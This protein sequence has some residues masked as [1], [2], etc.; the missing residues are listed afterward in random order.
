M[1]TVIQLKCYTLHTTQENR[2]KGKMTYKET[3]TE[4]IKEGMGGG[5]VLIWL[6]N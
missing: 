5:G 2:E 6:R 4:R 1:H 3:D